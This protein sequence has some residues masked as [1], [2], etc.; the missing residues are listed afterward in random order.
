MHARHVAVLAVAV[1]LAVVAGGCL[2]SPSS[3]PNAPSGNESFTVEMLGNATHSVYVATHLYTDR[4]EFVTLEY[5]NGTTREFELPTE[6]GLFQGDTPDGLRSVATPEDDGGVYFE[7][8]PTF[9]ASANEIAP[10]ETVVFVVRVD[11]SNQ[12]AAWGVA[13]CDGHVDR[14]TLD[15]DGRNVTVG[16]LACSN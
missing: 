8:S 4:P 12:V 9:T 14:V 3:G 13:N 10:M 11:G 16:G 2:G 7:G 6:Q 5:A 15:A 1:A